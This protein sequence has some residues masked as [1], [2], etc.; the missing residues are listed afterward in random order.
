MAKTTLLKKGMTLM[1]SFML[2]L[3]LSV[4]ALLM[5]F[6]NNL[7]QA[8]STRIQNNHQKIVWSIET[9]METIGQTIQNTAFNPSVQSLFLG[10]LKHPQLSMQS[11]VRDV[12]SQAFS[13]NRYLVGIALYDK[14]R[15]YLFSSGRV[16]IAP[17]DLPDYWGKIHGVTWSGSRE[18]G[19]CPGTGQI[20]IV[21]PIYEKSSS[22]LITSNRIG[23]LL[24]I[25]TTDWLQDVFSGK[26]EDAC[27]S[28]L[29]ADGEVI[30][31]Y[32]P[33]KGAGR[34]NLVN[35]CST[36]IEST[37]WEVR[38][39]L[40][41]MTITEDMKPMLILAVFSVA[42]AVF[43]LAWMMH[44]YRSAIS[45]PLGQIQDFMENIP[46]IHARIHVPNNQKNEL[47]DMMNVLNGMLSTLEAKNDELL[48]SKVHILEEESARQQMELIAYRNQV[49]PHF[50]YNT[51]DCMRGMALM[52][53]A[54][55]I[56]DMTQALSSMFHYTVR[57]DVTA[58]LSDEIRNV[59]NYAKIMAYRY[60]KAFTVELPEDPRFSR[61]LVIRNLL[62]PLVENAVVHGLNK[63]SDG[64]K[65]TVDITETEGK[66]LHIRVTDNG[67]GMT[68]E[69]LTDLRDQIAQTR[70]KD[71]E[72][73]P[74][75]AHIGLQNIMRRLFLHYGEKAA[76]EVSSS[77][78][79]GTEV[80]II[81]PVVE[82]E[83]EDR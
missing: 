45:T 63:A 11:L 79:W 37:G 48:Q 74:S 34:D 41:K 7:Q 64:G 53:K 71:L 2:V 50:L 9:D 17:D 60:T 42:M 36:E 12:F 23:Y 49:N 61:I 19:T 35:I 75:Q 3:C 57:G 55:E 43:L 69:Q 32:S 38:S 22:K 5:L 68:E 81:L 80:E 14:D 67:G 10:N 65:I 31:A 6:Y 47:L 44:Y 21:F 59:E 16:V 30:S 73:T 25:L 39:D 70:R 15:G 52:Y 28:L 13:Y 8:A 1:L 62:Q 58:T 20:H 18:A 29:S 46:D 40:I 72:T 78:E 26:G 83:A 82:M 54:P 77:P 56:V 51:L 33:E 27:L 24:F 66:M 76:I 4:S